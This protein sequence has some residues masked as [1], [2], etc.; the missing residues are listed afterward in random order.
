MNLI[1]L[2]LFIKKDLTILLPFN[3][4][5]F[6]VR[7]PAYFLAFGCGLGLVPKAPGTIASFCALPLVWLW[8]QANLSHSWL[9]GLCGLLF[10]LGAW[11]CEV[12][13]RAIGIADYSGFVIDEIVAMSIIL[14]YLPF[15][16]IGWLISFLLFRF[17]DIA[18]PWPI[19]QIDRRLKN[20]L[21]VMLDDV[22]AA[23]YVL[24]ICQLF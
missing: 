24:I 22:A 13:G 20:G 1:N 21:G 17:I 4:W 11:S 12:V 19:N 10:I 23:G 8:F 16:W 6:I 2:L 7:H 14:I 3:N 18:K 9:I 5:R 15:S